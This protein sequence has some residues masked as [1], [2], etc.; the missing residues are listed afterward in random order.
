VNRVRSL[1][2]LLATLSCLLA[3]A[4]SASAEGATGWYLM[5]PPVLH[6]VVANEKPLRTWQQI[7]TFESVRTCNAQLLQQTHEAFERL[8]PQHP[9]PTDEYGAA[10]VAWA[11]ASLSLCISSDDPIALTTSASAE[12]VLAPGP[13]APTSCA[14]CRRGMLQTAS[15]S[16]YSRLK[17][18][19]AAIDPMKDGEH[20]FSAMTAG[21]KR[22][23]LEMPA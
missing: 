16:E 23:I 2:I 14:A 6:G 12:P 11:Q 19:H 15:V 1:G 22:S 20:Q 7:G 17:L 10:V 9:A 4:T 5:V 8:N 13:G 3:V 21:R 18:E